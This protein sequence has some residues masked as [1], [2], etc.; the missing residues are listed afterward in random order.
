[1]MSSR[2]AVYPSSS[3]EGTQGYVV[4]GPVAEMLKAM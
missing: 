1:M 3:H 4:D 2:Y